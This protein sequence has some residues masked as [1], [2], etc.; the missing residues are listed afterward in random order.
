[1]LVQASL[2]IHRIYVKQMTRRNRD[3]NFAWRSEAKGRTGKK[4]VL[5][6]IICII[7]LF[8]G[9]GG[10]GGGGRG[11]PLIAQYSM[12]EQMY[13]GMTGF[14]VILPQ[15]ESPQSVFFALSDRLS[16]RSSNLSKRTHKTEQK[17]KH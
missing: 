7:L 1:M 12:A 9:G 10:G 11:R 2:L 5:V 14:S 16:A 13:N 6:C 17:D 15:L 3:L 4:T 8:L